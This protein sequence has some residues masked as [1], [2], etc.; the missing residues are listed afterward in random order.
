MGE[1]AEQ[2]R[3]RVAILGRVD[4]ERDHRDQHEQPAEQAVQQELDRRVL[5]LAHAEAPD[6]EVHRDQHGLEEHV[7]E[8]HVGRR[9]HADDHRLEEQQQREV[10]LH[11]APRPGP[12]ARLAGAGLAR[13][14]L[15]GAVLLNIGVVP[16]GEDDHRH[17]HGGQADQHQRDA[18]HADRVVH[19]ELRGSTGRSG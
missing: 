6:H 11:A 12:G 15:I 17:Q 4:V 2:E 5:A 13:A 14:G 9:E 16:G 3:A 8:E 10:G 1:L 7:E 18:V 19:A